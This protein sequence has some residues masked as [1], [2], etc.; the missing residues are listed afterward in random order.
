MED[1]IAQLNADK[2]YFEKELID[3]Q[4]KQNDMMEE[5]KRKDQEYLKSQTE[6]EDLS[7]TFEAQ[8]TQIRNLESGK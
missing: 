6:N 4:M 7:M 3:M 2:N 1:L 8:D 5:L